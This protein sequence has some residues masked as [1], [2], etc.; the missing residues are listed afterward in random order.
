MNICSFCILNHSW[1]N[2]VTGSIPNQRIGS[3]SKKMMGSKSVSGLRRLSTISE[4]ET[5]KP[6]SDPISHDPVGGSEWDGSS[7]SMCSDK[8][9]NSSSHFSSDDS[10]LP[11]TGGIV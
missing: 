6:D 5:D 10:F 8:F 9:R 1:L 3:P 7:F 11:D 4:R 2:Y